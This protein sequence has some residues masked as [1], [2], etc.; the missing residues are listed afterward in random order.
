MVYKINKHGINRYN[1]GNQTHQQYKSLNTI[2]KHV[3]ETAQRTT[4]IKK[5]II[6][7][8]GIWN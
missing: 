2:A 7:E 6:D 4:E 1:N 5:R 8:T 3:H